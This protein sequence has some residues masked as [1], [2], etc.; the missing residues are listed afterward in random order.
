LELL[1]FIN[2]FHLLQIYQVS[3]LYH[4]IFYENKQIIT[5]LVLKNFSF[6]QL[7]TLLDNEKEFFKEG[8]WGKWHFIRL[9][10]I[11]P[12]ISLIQVTQKYLWLADGQY[13]DD[14]KGLSQ[15][16]HNPKALYKWFDNF[17]MILPSNLKVLQNKKIPYNNL[18]I[19]MAIVTHIMKWY[20]FCHIFENHRPFFPHFRHTAPHFSLMEMVTMVLL[21]SL[22]INLI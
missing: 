18:N 1:E 20:I 10:Y 4:S 22:S 9:Y 13:L 21:Y 5:F 16:H 2:Y 7:V 8:N 3:S 17:L 14:P 19:I 11:S 12:F 6:K 15:I